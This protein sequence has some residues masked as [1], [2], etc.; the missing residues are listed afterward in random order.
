MGAWLAVIAARPRSCGRA[1]AVPIH[2][3]HNA[4]SD[5]TARKEALGVALDAV[6]PLPLLLKPHYRQ[7]P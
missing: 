7:G 2:N 5:W 6:L 3:G 1:T 4:D